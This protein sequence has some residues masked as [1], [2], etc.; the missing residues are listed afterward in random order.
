MQPGEEF[1]KEVVAMNIFAGFDL[2]S[3][4]VEYVEYYVQNGR[5]RVLK[6][7]TMSWSRGKWRGFVEEFGA[8]NLKVA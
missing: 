7:G 2:A 5:G 4:S 1:S 8:E 6:R 3:E